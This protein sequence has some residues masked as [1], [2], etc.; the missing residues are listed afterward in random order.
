MRYHFRKDRRAARRI[1][2]RRDHASKAVSQESPFQ[3]REDAV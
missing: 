3:R 2:V 1:S